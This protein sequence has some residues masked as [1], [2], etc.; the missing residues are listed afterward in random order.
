MSVM[1]QERES[2]NAVFVLQHLHALPTGEEDVKLIGVYA[3]QA[4]AEAARDRLR[5]QPGFAQQPDGFT[6]AR[7]EIGKDHWTEGFVTVVQG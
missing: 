7:Y 6:I 1:R 4:S 3:S 5:R 2:I